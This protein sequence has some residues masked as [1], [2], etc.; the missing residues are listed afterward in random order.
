MK[1]KPNTTASGE[2]VCAFGEPWL[3]PHPLCRQHTADVCG[4]AVEDVPQPD[5]SHL[6]VC[7]IAA[8]RL[9]QLDLFGEETA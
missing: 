7:E 4:R 2:L 5:L 1:R 3:G 9:G 8:T 6:A